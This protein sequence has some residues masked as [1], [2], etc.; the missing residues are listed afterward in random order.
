VKI[1]DVVEILE[2]TKANI[3]ITRFISP[4]GKLIGGLKHSDVIEA[5]NDIALEYPGAHIT[6]FMEGT[7]FGL[8]INGEVTYIGSPTIQQVEL[9]ERI[10]EILK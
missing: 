8:V 6:E 5:V 1:M 7:G 10:E 3:L 2:F 4:C 9:E